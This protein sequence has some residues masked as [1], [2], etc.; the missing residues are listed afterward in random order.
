MNGVKGPVIHVPFCFQPIYCACLVIQRLGNGKDLGPYPLYYAA[1]C[2]DPRTSDFEWAPAEDTAIQAWAHLSALVRRYCPS[3]VLLKCQ[4]E[5]EQHSLTV[6]Q[7]FWK[8]VSNKAGATTGS[9]QDDTISLQVKGLQGE[10]AVLHSHDFNLL[11]WWQDRATKYRAIWPLAKQIL[12]TPASSAPSE[13]TFSAAG[14]VVTC[15]RTALTPEH[16]NQLTVLQRYYTN[17]LPTIP[18]EPKDVVQPEYMTLGKR[19]RT[20][21]PP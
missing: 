12:A 13:R 16:V 9:S 19:R 5:E 17:P 21:P 15:D 1:A 11:V 6:V 10:N 3:D 20:M 4:Q 8:R 2:L 14:R 18:A 7:R